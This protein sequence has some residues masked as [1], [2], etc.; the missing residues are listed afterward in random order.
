ML[1]KRCFD[2]WFTIPG[3]LILSP[4]LLLIAV[5]IRLD[6]KG[7]VF[8]RQERVGLDGMPFFIFKFRTMCVDAPLRGSQITVG[9]DPRVT[10]SG[11]FLR[12]YKLDELP[13]LFNVLIGEMSLVGPRPEVPRYV[14]EY[15]DAEKKIILSVLPGITDN[16]SILYRHENEVLARAVDPERAYIEEVLPIK[17]RCYVQYVK[18]RNL[19]MDFTII[20]RTFS[21]ISGR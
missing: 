6:S 18:E 15:G 7:P 17:I 14:M 13:Q 9:A 3:L 16:A 8:F 12:R 19:W 20:L 1:A 5:W 4:V 2:L 11:R 10:V 21:A